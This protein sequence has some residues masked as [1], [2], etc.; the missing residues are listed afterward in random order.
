MAN[1][2]LI[3]NLTLVRASK[4]TVIQHPKSLMALPSLAPAPVLATR[5]SPLLSHPYHPMTQIHF[6]HSNLRPNRSLLTLNLFPE[7]VVSSLLSL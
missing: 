4:T 2:A 3:R 6:S 1:R 7:A 5:S